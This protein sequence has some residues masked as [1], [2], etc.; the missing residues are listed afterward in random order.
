VPKGGLIASP[1]AT[2]S[3]LEVARRFLDASVVRNPRERVQAAVMNE[4]FNVWS[5]ANGL[6][7]WSA[8]R[9]C[10]AL[11]DCGVERR[12]S[13]VCWWVGVQLT[14]QPSD[15]RQRQNAIT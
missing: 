13:S 8:R 4:A 2:T 11:T 6:G 1:A 15:F 3:D 12:R 14:R 10:V 5:E 7:A 9:L